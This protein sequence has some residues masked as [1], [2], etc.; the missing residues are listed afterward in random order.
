MNEEAGNEPQREIIDIPRQ[1]FEEFLYWR[2]QMDLARGQVEGTMRKSEEPGHT[3]NIPPTDLYRGISMTTLAKMTHDE[4]IWIAA[5]L[6]QQ[7]LRQIQEN[8]AQAPEER[9]PKSQDS[10]PGSVSDTTRPSKRTKRAEE[11]D[12]QD[13]NEDA[14]RTP[15]HEIP[16]ATGLGNGEEI[17]D[18]R[19]QT[20]DFPSEQSAEGQ[21]PSVSEGT[22]IYMKCDEGHFHLISPQSP[23]ATAEAKIVEQ[24]GNPVTEPASQ[25]AP[26]QQKE[27]QTTSTKQASPPTTHQ[28]RVEQDHHQTLPVEPQS[29]PMAPHEENRQLTGSADEKM[30]PKTPPPKLP[31]IRPR[32]DVSENPPQAAQYTPRTT[33]DSDPETQKDKKVS[34]DKSRRFTWFAQYQASKNIADPEEMP[35]EHAK[36]WSDWSDW[37]TWSKKQEKWKEGSS[38][39]KWGDEKKSRETTPQHKS[40]RGRWESQDEQRWPNKWS[41]SAQHS[42]ESDT[43]PW[44]SNENWLESA[45]TAQEEGTNPKGKKQKNKGTNRKEV[46]KPKE[47][48]M[49]TE[50]ISE[51]DLEHGGRQRRQSHASSQWGQTE[52]WHHTQQSN[53]QE[54]NP[55]PPPAPGPPRPA[56]PDRFEDSPREELAPTAHQ[57]SIVSEPMFPHGVDLHKP[58]GDLFSQSAQYSHYDVRV[59]DQTMYLLH[60]DSITLKASLKVWLIEMMLQA[61]D[62]VHISTRRLGHMLYTR[63]AIKMGEFTRLMDTDDFA[64]AVS[65]LTGIP[66]GHQRQSLQQASNPTEP[67]ME[68]KGGSSPYDVFTIF[69]TGAPQKGTASRKGKGKGTNKGMGKAGKA[70]NDKGAHRFYGSHHTMEI[71]VSSAP[72]QLNSQLQ[73]SAPQISTPNEMNL[74]HENALNWRPDRPTSTKCPETTPPNPTKPPPLQPIMHTP[75]ADH[76]PR[77]SRIPPSP[78]HPKP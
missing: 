27:E 53:L 10:N 4:S 1:E 35:K 49:P 69:D 31:S 62:R 46:P 43:A 11:T 50:Q 45:G 26:S 77:S 78:P 28:Q 67:H 12:P 39:D 17:P 70:G 5:V 72:T 14:Q 61:T 59:R 44:H 15:Q 60:N 13:G 20:Q 33:Q 55:P 9:P 37:S 34:R 66:V 42:K 7:L 41:K 23:A 57:V 64:T 74:T 16:T 47:R 48:R 36:D 22:A 18:R 30:L 29:A 21:V 56:R 38:K 40:W 3:D 73:N 68:G 24:S 6:S 76:N 51:S 52:G 63:R 32:E 2:R 58:P 8:K 71:P 75:T 54:W 65:D 25:P 19:D